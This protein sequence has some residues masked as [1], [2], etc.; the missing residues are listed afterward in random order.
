MQEKQVLFG[1][2]PFNTK[3]NED[4]IKTLL[5]LRFNHYEYVDVLHSH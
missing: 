4:Y 1:I 3:L 2:S 5:A